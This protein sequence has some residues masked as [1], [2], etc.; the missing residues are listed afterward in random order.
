MQKAVILLS[1]RFIHVFANGR[2]SV[3]KVEYYSCVCVC[4]SSSWL[5]M[6]CNFFI[7]LSTDI[8]SFQTLAI[9]IIKHMEAESRM[10]V[11]R[12]EEVGKMGRGVGIG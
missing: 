11:T 7:H 10:V 5:A 6:Y 12:A 8:G 9:A 4:V 2:I 3:F 1:S